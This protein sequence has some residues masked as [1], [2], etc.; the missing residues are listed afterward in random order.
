MKSCV[1]CAAYMVWYGSPLPLKGLNQPIKH[2]PQRP[3][4]TNHPPTTLCLQR[5]Q[6][7]VCSFFVRGECNRGAECPYRHEMPLSGELSEQNIKDRCV[8]REGGVLPGGPAFSKAAAPASPPLFLL[9]LCTA[10]PCWA[11]CYLL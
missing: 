1:W 9:P 3:Q 4:P 10:E 11:P 5:N 6:A 8:W 7:K 2:A